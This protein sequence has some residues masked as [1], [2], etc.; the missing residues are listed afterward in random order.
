VIEAGIHGLGVYGR[1]PLTAD[2]VEDLPPLLLQ[3]VIIAA[4]RRGARMLLGAF[5]PRRPVARAAAELAPDVALEPVEDYLMVSCSVAPGTVIPPAEEWTPETPAMLRD[6]MLRAIDG[7]HPA[8][9]GIVERTDL[10]SIFVIPFGHLDPA[11]A[12]EP[13]RVTLIGDAAHAMLPTLGMGANLALRDF[14][15]GALERM[16][17]KAAPAG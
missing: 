8:M 3:G 5:R 10:S 13:S 6:S 4:D 15:G 14:G 12:W 9:R 2:V 1:S 7:W 11:P 17:E 16:R